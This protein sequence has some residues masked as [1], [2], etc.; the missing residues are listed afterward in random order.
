MSSRS[1]DPVVRRRRRRPSPRRDGRGRSRRS[2]DRVAAREAA[3]DPDRV[4]RRLGARVREAPLGQAR[5]G[6]RAP[7]RRR[8][9][10]RS[11]RRSACP[12]RTRSAIAST[13]AG[14]AWPCT[15]E[16]KPLWKSQSSRPSTSQTRCALAA[17]EVD[18]PRVARMVRGRDAERH[19]FVRALEHALR[20]LRGLVEP[21]RSRA[22]SAP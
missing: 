1:T 9:R 5:S 19:H 11:A 4:H 7:R 22:R 14:C 2:S 12:A 16:P 6:A 13:I 15:I 10:P 3:R 17:L 8:S 21:L 20:L 18:R